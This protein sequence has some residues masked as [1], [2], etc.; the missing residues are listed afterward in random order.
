MAY[1]Q[2]PNYTALLKE[3][4][5]KLAGLSVFKHSSTGAK[6]ILTDQYLSAEGQPVKSQPNQKESGYY[7]VD[8]IDKVQPSK[9][10][11][12]IDKVPNEKLADKWIVLDSIP[13]TVNYVK[14][15]KPKPINPGGKLHFDYAA[16]FID[17]KPDCPICKSKEVK[18]QSSV[19]EVNQKLAGKLSEHFAN[20]LSKEQPP[21]IWDTPGI[22][23]TTANDTLIA[24]GSILY[25]YWPPKGGN[26]SFH[27]AAVSL[28]TKKVCCNL[29]VE[30]LNPLSPNDA[31]LAKTKFN[32]FLC[33]TCFPI[34]KP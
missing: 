1:E 34:P 29:S 11:D 16:G 13:S 33:P 10:I 15:N 27:C 7:F 9:L 25:L 5:S 19:D 23:E 2:N 26:P 20:E 18:K 30:K 31:E 17:C 28:I 4:E 8:D 21:V 14:I 24:V 12:Y 6:S 22:P 3:I 32:A